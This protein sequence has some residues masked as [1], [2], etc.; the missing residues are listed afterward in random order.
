MSRKTKEYEA[1]CH[2]KIYHDGKSAQASIEH[3]LEYVSK[4]NLDLSNVRAYA[5]NESPRDK[6]EVQMELCGPMKGPSKLHVIKKLVSTAKKL[7]IDI[8][9]IDI[10]EP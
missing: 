2:I 5:H 10:Y 6:Y 7:N 3:C 9:E 4:F 1:R 8:E